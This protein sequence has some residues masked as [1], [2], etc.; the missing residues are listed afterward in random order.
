MST[1]DSPERE[2]DIYDKEGFPSARPSL[3]DTKGLSNFSG[4][5]DSDMSCSSNS[6]EKPKSS[7]PPRREVWW[8]DLGPKNQSLESIKRRFEERLDCFL[9]SSSTS[10]LLR[11]IISPMDNRLRH[12]LHQCPGYLREEI[13]LVSDVSKSVIISHAFP[14]QSEVCSIC[15]QLVQYKCTEP[16]LY[17]TITS[18]LI[19]PTSLLTMPPAPISKPTGTSPGFNNLSLSQM[20]IIPADPVVLPK[21]NDVALQEWVPPPTR[22]AEYEMV[23]PDEFMDD[24]PFMYP[25]GT[26][27]ADPT[28]FRQV[29]S[30]HQRR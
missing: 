1:D 16:S 7:R 12:N 21:F 2:C 26:V 14:S 17:P 6:T 15:G 25:N 3:D 4:S 29:I 19:N 11:H 10:S 20:G 28:T 23:G 27:N 30:Y 5:K 18:H 9:S 22:V 13:T 24:T 8:H